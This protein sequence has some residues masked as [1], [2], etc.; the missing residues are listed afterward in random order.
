MKLSIDW[1]KIPSNFNLAS[2]DKDGTVVVYEKYP[3]LIE[4]GW[5]QSTGEFLEDVK[6]NAPF[7]VSEWR[8]SV[9]RR[10]SK[11]PIII[12][13]LEFKDRIRLVSA[14]DRKRVLDRL[15]NYAKDTESVPAYSNSVSPERKLFDLISNAE[16]KLND[17]TLSKVDL[18]A[19]KTNINTMISHAIKLIA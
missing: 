18:I 6:L 12:R 1:S 2:I 4:F 3:I 15:D 11:N 8:N 9:T 13:E 10:P 14:R 19:H 5:S 16:L 7:D 17:K